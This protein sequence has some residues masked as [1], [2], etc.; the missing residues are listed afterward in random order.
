[1]PT[2]A[3]GDEPPMRPSMPTGQPVLPKVAKRQPL[4][5]VAVFT[6]A[7]KRCRAAGNIPMKYPSNRKKSPP[8]W[9]ALGVRTYLWT[10]KPYDSASCIETTHWSGL[11]GSAVARTPDRP[12]SLADNFVSPHGATDQVAP[13][14]RKGSA[15][16]ADQ[17]DSRQGIHQQNKHRWWLSDRAVA[18]LL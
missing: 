11:T 18:Q 14:R 2:A 1:M 15:V 7:P 10:E 4:R 16:S 8:G 5:V 9:P 17:A 3:D 12:N 6:R 13:W